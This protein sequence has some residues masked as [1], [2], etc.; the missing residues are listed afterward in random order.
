M[1][2]WNK[3][4]TTTILTLRP[5]ARRW[6]RTA[7]RCTLST[8]TTPP[9]WSVGEAWVEHAP[10][11]GRTP[12][13]ARRQALEQNP[14]ALH[15]IDRHDA[16]RLVGEQQSRIVETLQRAEALARSQMNAV[17]EKALSTMLQVQTGEIRRLVA[18]K[19]VNP[20][21]REEELEYLKEQTLQLHDSL[22]QAS[23]ELDAV[24]VIIRAG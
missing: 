18:L 9:V 7:T 5:C 15:F 3:S 16:A 1:H 21:V 13:Q 8:A 17:I 23:L 24:H 10:N 14:A 20:N 12:T 19:Q 6:S 4:P 2:G 11:N 22:K